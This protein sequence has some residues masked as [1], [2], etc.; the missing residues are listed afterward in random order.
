MGMGGQT[1]DKMGGRNKVGTGNVCR[2]HSPKQEGSSPWLQM[3][4]GGWKGSAIALPPGVNYTHN[5]ALVHITLYTLTCT[6]LHHA[7]THT[8]IRH[9]CDTHAPTLMCT[10]MQTTRGCTCNTHI[11]THAHTSVHYVHM[12]VHTHT[13]THADSHM[14]TQICMLK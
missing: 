14:H 6:Y 8:R 4:L 13:P 9:A 11:Y 3:Y 2:G 12:C 10:D 1:I 7:F 5:P